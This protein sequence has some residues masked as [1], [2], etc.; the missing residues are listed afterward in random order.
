[1][2]EGHV[3]HHL[4]G[5]LNS[6]FA[7]KSLAATSPQSRFTAEAAVIDGST[8]VQ[9]EAF[10]KHLFIEFDAADPAHIIYIHLGLIGTLQ[11]EPVS[12]PRGQVRLR[13]SDGITAADLRGPQW[14]RLI[15]EAEQDAAVG[16]LGADPIRT[17]ADPEP[18]WQK[19]KRS[20]RSIGSLLMDQKLFAG[21]GNI[22]RAETLFRLGIS[23]FR[24]GNE[25]QR[26]EFDSIWADLVG[27]MAEGVTAARI[28]TVRPEH[29]PEAMGRPPRK[30]DHGGEV[31]TYRRTG[32]SC[33]VCGTDITEQVMEGRN[34]FWC[35]G[36]QAS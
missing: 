3:I 30:D 12:I 17:D 28:D 4:A 32:Q 26:N 22:Y 27:L 19:V 10:G 21:V 13:L 29:T 35:P 14:C 2:P 31:Y 9:A 6:R 8:L 24:T 34:L 25:L 7:G 20:T 18:I 23:P 16:K 11:F 15:T 33:Y 36:C 1:M 5:Q